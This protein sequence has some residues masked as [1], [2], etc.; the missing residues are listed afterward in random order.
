MSGNV[1]G[2]LV[3]PCSFSEPKWYVGG[4]FFLGYGTCAFVGS[5]CSDPPEAVREVHPYKVLLGVREDAVLFGS[6]LILV[7]LFCAQVCSFFTGVL[8][9]EYLAALLA[10]IP[11]FL[12]LAA[13]PLR[14][15]C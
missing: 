7:V 2:V 14:P 6:L 10:C 12:A 13:V 9:L 3:I 8:P 4:C 11:T 5:K 15:P 1:F